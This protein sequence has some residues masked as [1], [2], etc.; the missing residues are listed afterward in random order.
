M[1]ASANVL[2]ALC[3]VLVLVCAQTAASYSDNNRFTPQPFKQLSTQPCYPYQLITGPTASRGDLL[4]PQLDN[5]PAPTAG[6]LFYA[7]N[8]CGYSQGAL[9]MPATNDWFALFAWSVPEESVPA[10]LYDPT[11]L[12]PLSENASTLLFLGVAGGGRIF[13]PSEINPPKDTHK[14]DR[15]WRYALSAGVSGSLPQ[16]Y[17]ERVGEENEL[18]E[19]RPSPLLASLELMARLVYHF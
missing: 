1:R 7:T 11:A 4:L 19:D 16:S 5:G 12:E 8:G 18:N 15:G 6:A 2:A 17:L 13:T 3:A 9:L 14:R 10:A